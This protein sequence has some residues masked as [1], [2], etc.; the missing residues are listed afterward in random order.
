MTATAT[1]PLIPND[2]YRIRSGNPNNLD[3]YLERKPDGSVTVQPSK[4]SSDSQMWTISSAAGGDY[5][6]T[7]VSN[8]R[9]GNLR[10]ND[11]NE[12]ECGT[13]RRPTSTW[14]IEPRDRDTYVIGCAANALAIN[15]PRQ[16][17]QSQPVTASSRNNRDNQRWILDPNPL[18]VRPD[19]TQNA[20]QPG[21]GPG[22][23]AA[24]RYT[25]GTSGNIIVQN[26]LKVPV[27]VAVSSSNRQNTAEPL[28]IAAGSRYNW[29][30]GTPEMV[31]VSTATGLGSFRTYNGR[32]GFTL[33]IDDPIP[34]LQWN[35]VTSAISGVEYAPG[36]AGR[37]VVQN[38]LHFAIYV[39]VMSNYF[40]PASHTVSRF[41][42][43]PGESESWTRHGSQVV[44]VSMASTPGLV[45]AYHGRIGHTLIIKS[46]DS[47]SLP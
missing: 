33:H 16:I 39:I 17:G 11:I 14:T 43:S 20:T 32:V 2:V 25:S 13:A 19:Q 37:I 24:G 21:S 7:S 29:M 35:G 18:L 30:R 42:I 34:D 46:A 27:Y 40:D 15:L 8:P 44:L 36:L 6:I 28:T 45:R 1:L 10:V 9:E 12:L 41:A 31:H 3:A 26:N 38:T 22:T 47:M 23:A 4:Q 5:T